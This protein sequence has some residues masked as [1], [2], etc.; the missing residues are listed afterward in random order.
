MIVKVYIM[1]NR[2]PDSNL[3]SCN[4]C[5]VY[6]GRSLTDTCYPERQPNWHP[7]RSHPAETDV[8]SAG[9]GA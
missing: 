7:E 6:T 5:C 8:S 9:I 4:G 2:T 3:A 1:L